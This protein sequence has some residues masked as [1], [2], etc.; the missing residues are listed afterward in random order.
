MSV[1]EFMNLEFKN[2][3][4]EAPKQTQKAVKVLIFYKVSFE[5]HSTVSTLWQWMMK[6]A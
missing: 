5:K 2:F 4:K 6:T 1:V 3:T